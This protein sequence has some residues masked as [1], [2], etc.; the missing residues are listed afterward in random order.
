MPKVHFDT[1]CPRGSPS[2]AHRARVGVTNPGP[3][4][5]R[6]PPKALA[7]RPHPCPPRQ[8]RASAG[9]AG[10][11]AILGA[12]PRPGPTTG[13]TAPCPALKAPA[14][15]DGTR[16]LHPPDNGARRPCERLRAEGR[17][18]SHGTRLARAARRSRA[19][20]SP[21][22]PAPGRFARPELGPTPPTADRPAPWRR[23]SAPSPSPPTRS[24][25]ACP[26][27]DSSPTR[28]PGWNGPGP[29]LAQ[30]FPAWQPMAKG[31][32]PDSPRD[33]QCRVFADACF[34][35]IRETV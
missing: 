17:K 15:V 22:Q 25:L 14:V 18:C 1:K 31:L 35:H 4:T 16:A 33:R 28:A 6:T 3:F 2:P 20:A 27:Q 24:R 19:R 13:S 29:R 34:P 26:E 12:R 9:S 7:P 30:A 21:R 10:R 23:G 8:S 32:R 5:E 11:S